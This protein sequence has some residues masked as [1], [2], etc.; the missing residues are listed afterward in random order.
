[1]SNKAGIV[2]IFVAFYMLHTSILIIQGPS[3]L[4]SSDCDILIYCM[5]TWL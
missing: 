1:M 2:I 4:G 3:S 5:N